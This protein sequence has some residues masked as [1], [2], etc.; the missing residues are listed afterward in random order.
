MALTPLFDNVLVIAIEQ[1][2]SIEGG[3]VLLPGVSR[4]DMKLGKVVGTGQ[5]CR[6]LKVGDLVTFGPHAGM[7]HPIQGVE[8][9]LMRE[10]EVKGV[11][12]GTD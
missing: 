8:F 10:Q 2:R 7:P 9:L 3:K 4:E 5:D 1:D 6:C 12:D 11:F